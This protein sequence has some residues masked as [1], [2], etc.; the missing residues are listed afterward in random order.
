MFKNSKS[1][2]MSS[3]QSFDTNAIDRIA[4]GTTLEGSV[5]S[6]K[7]IRVDGKVKGSIVCAGRVVI[8]KTGVVEGEVD[9]DSADVEGTLNA[10]ITVSGLL[11]LKATA[12]I[13][14]DSQVGKL[15]V[16]PGAEING[17]IDM[18]GTLKSISNNKR[19][20]IVEKTA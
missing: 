6:A 4:E 12:V 3:P 17:K 16:D 18:G 19:E 9:C 5:N 15:K 8:G 20:T 10:T 2:E 14:G 7:S 11:E 13:N 1:E